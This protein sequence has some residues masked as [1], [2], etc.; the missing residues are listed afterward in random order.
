MKED[1]Y[2]ITCNNCHKVYTEETPMNVNN[3]LHENKS[4]VLQNS[5]VNALVDHSNKADH[6]FDLRMLFQIKKESNLLKHIFN[7]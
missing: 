4:V 6:N 5:T 3:I 2:S 1:F 7:F